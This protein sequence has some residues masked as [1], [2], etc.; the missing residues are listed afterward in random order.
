MFGM[1]K[2]KIVA[3]DLVGPFKA[4]K[5]GNK[6][7][8]VCVDAF[9][10]WVEAAPLKTIDAEEV[11]DTI[12]KIIITQH[13]CPKNILTDQGRQFTSKL[14]Q[15]FCKKLKINKLQCSSLHPQTNGKAE[16]FISFLTNSLSTFTNKDQSDWDE[17]LYCCLFAYRTTIHRILKETPFYLLYGR[18][19]V[20]PNDLM[21]QLPD[22][23]PNIS[24]C[25]NDKT[26][27]NY[28]IE[29]LSRLKFAY[30]ALIAR[31]DRSMHDYK[32]VYGGR[33]RKIE[34]QVSEEVM[35]FW[36][37]RKVGF[38][39]KLLPR[40]DGPY[41]IVKRLSP[42]TYRIEKGNKNLVVHVQRLR[43]YEPW[44]KRNL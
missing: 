17:A 22:N 40:W 4:T 33:H 27:M 10:N 3:I 30:D 41:R 42:V 44:L 23:Q 34:F 14:F 37:V 13:G 32:N 5:R 21:F 8:V 38:T 6:Y 24:E 9:T 7:I 39:Q 18:D 36:P 26:K 31:K 11:C 28:K 25:E 12:F 43:H 20:L 1:R 2:N 16:R 29:L 15:E 35:L 19:V